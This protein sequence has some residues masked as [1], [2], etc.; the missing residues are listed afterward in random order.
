MKNIKNMMKHIFPNEFFERPEYFRALIL[1]VLY[2]GVLLCQLFTFEKFPDTVNGYGLVDGG[3]GVAVLA[4]A[5]VVIEAMALPFLLSM[6]LQ[7]VWL[8]ISR[9]AVAAVPVMWLLIGVWINLSPAA[10]RTN[11]GL[12]GASIVTPV[13][14][15]II[16]LAAGWLWAA[17]LVVR[18][19]PRRKKRS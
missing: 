2:L 4:G 7:G 6:R 18:E 10:D 8:M 11:T 9:W 16:A 15:W 5:I 1:G 13:Q 3:V 12:F 14:L 17:I 19:L